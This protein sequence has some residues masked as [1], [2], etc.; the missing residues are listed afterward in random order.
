MKRMRVQTSLEKK[1]SLNKIISDNKTKDNNTFQLVEVS[2]F[3]LLSNPLETNHK[4][5][6]NLKIRGKN[7][8]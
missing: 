2:N 5:K 3:G 6:N 7:K 1:R 4:I 8:I